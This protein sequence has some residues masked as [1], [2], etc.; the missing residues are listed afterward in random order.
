MYRTTMQMFRFQGGLNGDFDTVGRHFEWSVKGVYGKYMNDTW[1][2]SIA[3]QNLT[4][5]LNATT[6]ASGN[7]VCSPGSTNSTAVTRSSTLSLIHI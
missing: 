3:T 1:E 5:A 2:P 4:N 7:I 6:D